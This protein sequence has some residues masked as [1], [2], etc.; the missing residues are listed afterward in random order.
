MG[1]NLYIFS[2]WYIRHG[3]IKYKNIN[4]AFGEDGLIEE[5]STVGSKKKIR[6][7]DYDL[8]N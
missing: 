8:T 4:V 6:S 2:K 7:E 5:Q 1:G 3:N